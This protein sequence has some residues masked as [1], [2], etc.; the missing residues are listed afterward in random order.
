M[1][2]TDDTTTTTSVQ[3]GLASRLLGRARSWVA[4]VRAALSS[5]WASVPTSWAGLTDRVD[6]SPW[7]IGLPV[8]LLVLVIGL[9][10]IINDPFK[11]RAT[12]PATPTVAAQPA[13][14]LLGR[15][16][17]LEADVVDLRGRIAD[18]KSAQPPQAAAPSR[19]VATS[20]AGRS[21]RASAAAPTQP[22]QPQPAATWGTTD[23]DRAIDTFTTTLQE[24][25][26]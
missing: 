13:T 11:T 8:G 23:L 2:P 17:A 4:S 18:L 16:A 19:S 7:L 1:T 22:A 3:Q 14:E 26:K 24:P 12:Q 9:V 5:A 6:R 21:A 20:P 25:T 10:S 15:V